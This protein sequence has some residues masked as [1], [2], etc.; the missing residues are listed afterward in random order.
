MERVE[1]AIVGAGFSGLAMA[2]RLKQEGFHDFVVLERGDDLGGTW[3]DNAYPGCQCDIASHLYSY[4]FAPNPDWS[5]GL[6][7]RQE[8]H[9][10]LRDCAE[11][12]GVMPHLRLRHDATAIEW[13]EERRRWRIETSAGSF[14]S[15]LVVQATGPMSSPRLPEVPGSFEGTAFHSM[16]WPRDFDPTG[17]R[18]A[19]VGTGASAIQIVPAIQPL[20]ERLVVVQRTP[21]WVTPKIRRRLTRLE[22]ALYRRVPVTQRIARAALFAFYE[23]I[24]VGLRHPR[25]AA[26][27][28]RI[29]WL[30]A[31]RGVRDP[32]LRER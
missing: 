17:R 9:A 25:L 1:I 4:S 10:Y 5:H 8:I 3:R 29:A 2:I 6:S 13:D 24:I 11:R 21:P 26:A 12:F 23:S 14:D 27:S 19:V 32:E 30:N 7:P 18:V 31:R 28:E 20:V 22:R 16:H 15:K